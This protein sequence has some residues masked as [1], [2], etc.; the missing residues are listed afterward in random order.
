[1]AG[2]EYVLTG[3]ESLS[4]L[5]QVSTLG[6]V[7]GRSLRFEETTPER[8]RSE[9]P[10]MPL[11]I[12]TMLLKAWAGATDVPALVTSTVAEVTGTP[13]RTFRH[14]AADHAADFQSLPST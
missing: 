5:D 13:P 4:Q 11:A 1:C 6:H 7:L 10:A 8:W 2:C 3:P 14:W 9:W 12:A